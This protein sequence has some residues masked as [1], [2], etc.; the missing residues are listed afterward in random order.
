MDFGL[1]QLDRIVA[2]VRLTSMERHAELLERDRL[3]PVFLKAVEATENRSDAG[4][5]L[6]R[7]ERLWQVIIGAGCQPRDAIFRR[8]PCRQEDYRHLA[9]QPELP[10]N[11][12]SIEV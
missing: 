9:P 11:F 6:L 12:E 8:R 1:R 4:D 2:D 10:Q 3:G 7:P 5:Q